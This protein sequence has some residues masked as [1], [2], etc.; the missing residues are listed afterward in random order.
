MANRKRTSVVLPSFEMN[1]PGFAAVAQ[2]ISPL[3]GSNSQ[4]VKAQGPHQKNAVHWLWKSH[5][6]SEIQNAQNPPRCWESV[7]A[8]T[9]VL[10]FSLSWELLLEHHPDSAPIS[11]VGVHGRNLWGHVLAP[12]E[13]I[14]SIHLDHPH[15][16]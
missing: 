15:P 14:F 4:V 12:L 16:I 2:L 8:P 9:I 3:S 7:P 1:M 13:I 10:G 6:M 11:D 5:E